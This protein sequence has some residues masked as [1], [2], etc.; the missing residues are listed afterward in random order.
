MQASRS[1]FFELVC[2]K[3]ASQDAGVIAAL[4]A[5]AVYVV[6]EFYYRLKAMA[7]DTADDMEQ[8]AIEHNRRLGQATAA[9]QKVARPLPKPERIQR[10]MFSTDVQL[11]LVQ[12]WRDHK[13]AIDQSNLAR[14]LALEMST[15]TCR[16]AVVALAKAGCLDRVNTP[17]GTTLVISNG[18]LEEIFATAL[19]SL[20]TCLE[21][22]RCGDRR[23]G[24]A[25]GWI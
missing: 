9:R 21:D 25:M 7:V 20:C 4:N 13:G 11:R 12:N 10:A 3:S 17:Y 1:L 14:F 15:E 8:L 19:K 2:Q 6:A 5:D 23:S 22:A 16:K 24:V 18:R